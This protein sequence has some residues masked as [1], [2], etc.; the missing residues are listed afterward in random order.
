MTAPVLPLQT[1]ISQSSNGGTKYRLNTMV[2]G[3]GYSQRTPDGINY[4]VKNYQL[5]WDNIDL[6]DYTTLLTFFDTIGDGR[7]FTWQPPGVGTTLKWVLA[8]EV[9]TNVRSGGVYGVQVSVL[10]T[11]DLG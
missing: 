11:F 1:K 8:S 9:K 3:D 6:T 10:Q 5:A 4:V 2:F 7:Y